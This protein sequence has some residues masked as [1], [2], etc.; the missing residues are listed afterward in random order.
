M[1]YNSEQNCP[2]FVHF[3]LS[4]HINYNLYMHNRQLFSV[5]HLAHNIYLNTTGISNI[6]FGSLLCFFFDFSFIG[7]MKDISCK[8]RFN[9]S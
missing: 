9:K 8:P 1:L 4:V 6:S 7:I 5:G 3:I 2:Y